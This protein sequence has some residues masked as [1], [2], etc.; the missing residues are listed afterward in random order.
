VGAEDFIVKPVDPLELL[1]RVQF[2]VDRN[3]EK[4]MQQRQ[5]G[6]TYDS[7]LKEL[8]KRIKEALSA[9]GTFVLALLSLGGAG[10]DQKQ[11]AAGSKFL[12]DGLRRGDLFCSP[13]PGYLIVLQPN[14]S[15]ASAKQ[16][17]ATLARRLKREFQ[18]ECRVGLA[19]CPT[20]GQTRPELMAAIKAHLDLAVQQ[21]VEII[22]ES[23]PSRKVEEP[24]PPKI[25]IVD[26]DPEFLNYLAKPLVELGINAIMES[27]S[28]R[29]L[30]RVRQTSPD[31]VM[32][33]VMMPDPDGL[34]I[35]QSL[36]ADPKLAAIPVIMVSVKTAEE[37]LIRAFDLGAADYLIKPFQLP[38]LKARVRKVL[39]AR[40][41][42][43]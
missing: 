43:E 34:K 37:Y 3:N 14:E 20:H 18:V 5:V 22:V 21:G 30:E 26:D 8:D 40:A 28:D 9:K 2:L 1:L 29:A 12:L 38:E 13:G 11:R 33:D 42:S 7:F 23:A 19:E 10:A 39:R 27:A 24:H 41:A 36:K 4:L 6:I 35:L 15:L 31:L 17:F 16:T 25:L 32:L